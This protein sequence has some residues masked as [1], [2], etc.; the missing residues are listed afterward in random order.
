MARR[1][2]VPPICVSLGFPDPEPLLRCALLEI[3]KGNRF[4]EIRLDHFRNPE[5]GLDCIS[6]L[7]QAAPG[8]QILATCRS[9]ECGG[10]FR[11]PAERQFR[12]L[13]DAVRHGVHWVDLEV[14][15]A[16]R[17]STQAAQLHARTQL[18]ISYHNFE[19][20]PSLDRILRRLQRHPATAYKIATTARKPSDNWR[21]LDFTRRNFRCR[22]ITLAMGEM[23]LCTRVL[24]IMY[25]GLYSYAAP[26]CGQPTAAGQLTSDELRHLYRVEKLSRSTKVY[27]VIGDPIGHSI[28]PD[29]HNHAFEACRLDAVYLPFWV[30][31][32]QLGDFFHLATGIGLAG[33]SV[34]IPHKQSVMRYLDK[35]EPLAVRIG[36]VNTVWKKQGRWRGTNTDV[37]GVL[38]P[39]ERRTPVSGARV[40]IAGSGG[41]ARAAAFALS[42][43]RAQV[44]IT[45]RNLQK[46]REIARACGGQ[47]ISREQAEQQEFD[48]L[49]H[50]TPLG[51]HPHP[52][53]CF[54]DGR[55]PARIVFD[56]VYRPVET[57]LLR[58][59]R[60]QGKMT[61]SGL[62]MLIE[63]AVRQFEIWTGREA[64]RAVMEQAAQRAVGLLPPE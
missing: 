6:Q 35:I 49:I 55:I 25:G 48:I 3:G 47:V 58:R 9:H 2:H 8:V 54:F 56:M 1:S 24:S 51:M 15:L 63:Q 32:G 44:F 4:F 7:R 5:T 18:I 14:E 13:A 34:T 37:D 21:L 64:P 10:N 16:E 31:R 29:I 43:Q 17:A 42:S 12:L 40:L 19:S 36:A 45:A 39:L 59:A 50:A 30:P 27:G 33:C 41:A 61:I 20:T 62:E 60:E 57:T 23:G 22:L 26:S 38:I 11:G 52:E 28:S 46:A 53:G